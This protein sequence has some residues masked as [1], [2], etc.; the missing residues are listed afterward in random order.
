[1]TLKRRKHN[2]KLNEDAL[3]PLCE[4]LALENFGICLKRD[5]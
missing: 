4:E 2:C 3:G 5:Y 1:M